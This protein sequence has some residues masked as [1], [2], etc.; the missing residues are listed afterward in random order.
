MSRRHCRLFRNVSD[1]E[2]SI[3]NMLPGISDIEIAAIVNFN[4]NSSHFSF[5]PF[6]GI[7]YVISRDM[8]ILIPVTREKES[9]GGAVS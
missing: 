2:R 1:R 5:L 8:I 9:V 6:H 7:N 3:M 4:L